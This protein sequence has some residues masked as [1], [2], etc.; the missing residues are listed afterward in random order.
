MKKGNLLIISGPSGVGK[1][2]VMRAFLQAHQDWQ[3]CVTIT[4]RPM[5]PGEKNGHDYIFVSREEF[6]KKIDNDEFLEW[7]EYTGNFYG[8]SR[9]SVEELIKKGLNIVLRVDIQGALYIKKQIPQAITICLL[10]DEE[11]ALEQR[12]RDRATDS[13]ELLR[14]RMELVKVELSYK[15]EFDHLVIN[16]HEHPEQPVAEIERILSL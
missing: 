2:T 6:K 1:D 12:F 10:P 4:S 11:E 15:N 13:E 5:R 7:I 8:T 9:A 16:P 14:A 3:R